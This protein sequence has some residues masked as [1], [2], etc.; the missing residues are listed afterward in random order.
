MLLVEYVQVTS[1]VY[2]DSN[3]QTVTADSTNTVVGPA[4]PSSYT[5][6]STVLSSSAQ[7][8]ETSESQSSISSSNPLLLLLL[9]HLRHHL[10]TLTVTGPEVPEFV[11]GLLATVH[12]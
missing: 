12:S 6:A 4:V 1:T 10:L 9:H 7:A 2:V 11:P 8:V 5:K 3:G